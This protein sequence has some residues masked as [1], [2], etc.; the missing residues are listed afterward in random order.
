MARATLTLVIAIALW[1]SVDGEGVESP[2]EAEMR[3]NVEVMR[4]LA[5][6]TDRNMQSWWVTYNNSIAAYNLH[7]NDTICQNHTLNTKELD[8]LEFDLGNI[9]EVWADKGVQLAKFYAIL[10][11]V[12]FNATGLFDDFID[13]YNEQYAQFLV[14]NGTLAWEED[15]IENLKSEAEDKVCP[16]QWTDWT[17]YTRYGH[18]QVLK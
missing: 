6:A 7:K 17:N 15:N 13:W 9:K 12:T 16:C 4:S 8:D 11:N 5:L 18:Y 10:S 1:A 2:R 3:S 14:E